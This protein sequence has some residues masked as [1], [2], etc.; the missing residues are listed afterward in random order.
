MHAS[1]SRAT[2]SFPLFLLVWR[3]A[4]SKNCRRIW[5][6]LTRIL[7]Q[8]IGSPLFNFGSFQ[9]KA[10]R[11]KS[12]SQPC[13]ISKGAMAGLWKQDDGE[14]EGVYFQRL[15][16]ILHVR[17]VFVFLE[18]VPAFYSCFRIRNGNDDWLGKESVEIVRPRGTSRTSKKMTIESVSSVDLA[19]SQVA[20]LPL[21]FYEQV[22][23]PP[24]VIRFARIISIPKLPPTE[25]SIQ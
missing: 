13:W 11:A 4:I 12:V 22:G 17:M 8:I 18:F 20:A 1:A 7:C 21:P 10:G 19:I 24:G 16:T 9:S 14:E 3:L 23:H 25:S 2:D 15:I 5:T 6:R